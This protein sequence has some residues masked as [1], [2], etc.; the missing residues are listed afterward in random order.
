MSKSVHVRARAHTNCLTAFVQDYPG[1]PVPEET[2]T[3]SHQSW[4]SDILYQFSPSAMMHSILHVQFTCLTVL[5]HSPS[6]GSLWS[7]SRSSPSHHLFATHTIENESKSNV[8]WTLSESLTV[9]TAEYTA[10]MHIS[11]LAWCR[12][13]LLVA[14][15]IRKSNVW[16]LVGV[17]ANN[18]TS[19]SHPYVLVTKQHNL[20]P[21]SGRWCYAAEKVTIGLAVC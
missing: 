3:Y 21:A 4:S 19:R 9:L 17:A 1:G 2:F 8:W 18:W 6:P 10:C 11:R 7:Y 14:L 16:L 15:A 5:F 20:T 13:I 12:S